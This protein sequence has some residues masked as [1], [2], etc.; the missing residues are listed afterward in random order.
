MRNLFLAAIFLVFCSACVST[1]N[2]P[3][4]INAFEKIEFSKITLSKREKPDFSATTPGKAVL[5]GIGVIAMI[6]AGNK[7]IQE[8]E[9]EDPA[10][11]I[12]AQLGKMLAEKYD[13]VEVGRSDVVVSGLKTKSVIDTYSGVG[14][15]LDVQTINW[16][17]IYFPTKWGKYKVIY[18][19]KLR[20]IDSDSGTLL[21]EGF[22]Q[23]VPEY[24]DNAP[25]KDQ[26]LAESAARLK[27]ELLLGANS[28]IEQLKMDV[29]SL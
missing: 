8:N 28:C 10:N 16:S 1:K 14:I 17:F 6:S 20:L 4:D 12:G 19:A 15:L 29:L 13:S 3:I 22:C 7:I 9:I 27:E 18:S 11:F 21:A 26:L 24:N 5:G 25:T 2:V 23:R